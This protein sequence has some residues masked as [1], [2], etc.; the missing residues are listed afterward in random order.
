MSDAV[1]RG[2]P[3]VIQAQP[4]IA[5][6]LALPRRPRRVAGPSRRRAT[7]GRSPS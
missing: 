4:F 1:R 5:A 2:L 6:L 7:R 3:T